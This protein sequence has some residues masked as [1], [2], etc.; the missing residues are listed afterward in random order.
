G[1]KFTTNRSVIYGQFN[2]T[3]SRPCIQTKAKVKLYEDK[4]GPLPVDASKS[5]VINKETEFTKLE[6]KVDILIT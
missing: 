5:D 4:F 1:V 2:W 6:P 3:S